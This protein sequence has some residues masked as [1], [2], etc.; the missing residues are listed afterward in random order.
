MVRLFNQGLA[1]AV[2]SVLPL[3]RAIDGGVRRWQSGQW[4]FRDGTMFLVPGD[5]PIG[6]RLPLDSLPWGDPDHLYQE[7]ETD[8]F[9]PRSHPVRRSN[10]RT[11]P[12][13]PVRVS[14]GFARSRKQSRSSVLAT[15]AA[16]RT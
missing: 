9:A 2:G 13:T 5:S 14:S 15:S 10:G 4:V 3:R 11:G 7:F 8:P 12:R 16:N 6:F 1:A